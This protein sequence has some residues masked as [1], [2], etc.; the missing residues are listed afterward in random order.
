MELKDNLRVIRRQWIMVVACAV[1]GLLIA[2]A[3]SFFTK[4]SYSSQ[5]KLFVALQ[6]SGSVSELTQGNTFSQA[7]V[8]SY[9]ETVTTPTVLQPVIEEL[10]LETTPESLARSVTAS[11]DPATV[12]ISITVENE[13]PDEATAVA[14]AVSRSLINA[15]DELERPSSSDA[16]PV[17]LSV[18]TPASEPRAPS[19]PN[20]A[21]NLIVGLLLGLAAGIGVALLRSTFDTR[22]R[23][24]ADLRR[25]TDAAILVGLSFDPDAAKS[26][27]LTQLGLQSPRAE[28]F[29][30]L[31]TNLQFAHVSHKSKTVLV[32]SSVPGEGKSTTA[33]N[34]AIALAQGGQRVALIDADLRRP[35]L[36][37][38][39]GLERDAGLTTFLIGAADLDELLQP[40]G[41]DQLFI[42]TAGQIPPN[43]SELLGSERMQQLI[44]RLEDA[45]DAVV[46]DA[47]PLLPVTDAAVLAQQV[48]GVIFVVSTQKA[49]TPEVE[50]SLATLKLVDADLLGVVLNRLPAK[51]PD[52][53]TYSYDSYV[54]QN[55]DP[56]LA[57]NGA[58]DW[59]ESQSSSNVE[60]DKIL[61]GEERSPSRVRDVR[62]RARKVR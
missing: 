57:S 22:V 55:Q 6:N 56:S 46:I 2:G 29:R 61:Y 49:R 35:A 10:D 43:P 17:K 30:Q 13:S 45:F 8:K 34:L 21:A 20:V 9:V 50:K 27:L 42:L 25:F 12:L 60:F 14:Q 47:P 51:G 40:W 54:L 52:A 39:F 38:Y 31:R 24:E 37:S 3:A 26:P 53:Y 59:S 48:G 58:A 7:R 11:S 5:T 23:G 4:P 19:S 62:A 16:S 41:D 44:M 33:A 28:S 15:V 32:T 36:D 1:I 18:I